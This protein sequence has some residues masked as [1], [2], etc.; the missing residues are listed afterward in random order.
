MPISFS[1]FFSFVKKVIHHSLSGNALKLS[2]WTKFFMCSVSK[3]VMN[4]PRKML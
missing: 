2:L 1:L 4:S 3:T